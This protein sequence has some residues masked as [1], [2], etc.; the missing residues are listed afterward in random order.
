MIE[1]IGYQKAAERRGL[2]DGY[3]RCLCKGG[4]GLESIRPSPKRVLFQHEALDAW[5]QTWFRANA[6]PQHE[7]GFADH[8]HCLLGA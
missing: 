2:Q 3:F 1:L 5:M 7:V 4:N 6:T 8:T